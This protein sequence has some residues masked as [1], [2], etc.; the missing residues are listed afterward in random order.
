MKIIKKFYKFSKTV[1]E[2]FN[3]FFYLIIFLVHFWVVGVYAFQ[4]IVGTK[5]FMR[6][7]EDIDPTGAIMIRLAGAS[8]CWPG[9]FNS[10]YIGFIRPA[11]LEGNGLS[12]I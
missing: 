9:F 6:K 2:K 12:L 3:N 4:T 7:I 5:S 11:G 8:L 10:I 1:I